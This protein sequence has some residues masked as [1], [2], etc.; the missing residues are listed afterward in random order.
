LK[1]LKSSNSIKLEDLIKS[2]RQGVVTAANDVFIVGEDKIKEFQIEPEFI[3]K[4]VKGEEI[5][6]WRK[7]SWDDN[8]LIYPYK[9]DPESKTRN[10]IRINE[11]ADM[12][13]VKY[14]ERNRKKLIK[15]YCVK[16]GNK[17]WFE[18]HDPVSPEYL[19]GNEASIKFSGASPLKSSIL[20]S[21]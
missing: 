12:N 16:S 19:L 1:K 14:L 9:Y 17:D 15:R 10:K 13:I 11:N 21:L 20:I 8:Y 3:Y 7:I 6:R 4:I 2:N 5:R 18:L